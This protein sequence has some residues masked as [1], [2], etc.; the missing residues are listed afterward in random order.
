MVGHSPVCTLRAALY[1]GWRFPFSAKGRMYRLLVGLGGSDGPS[2][3]SNPLSQATRTPL[4]TAATTPA[5]HFHTACFLGAA[6]PLGED[7][8]SAASVTA[9]TIAHASCPKLYFRSCLT[10]VPSPRLLAREAES[11]SVKARAS[12]SRSLSKA[13]SRRTLRT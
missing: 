9:D 3:L 13:T 11:G 5:S 10:K 2:S 6:E 12:M 4:I 7:S 8:L 1:L